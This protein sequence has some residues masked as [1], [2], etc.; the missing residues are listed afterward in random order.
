MYNLYVITLIDH[1][2]KQFPLCWNHIN[3]VNGFIVNIQL[4]VFQWLLFRGHH[5]SIL[6]L[7]TKSHIFFPSLVE[8]NTIYSLH[9]APW[10]LNTTIIVRYKQENGCRITNPDPLKV[11]Q[12]VE[13]AGVPKTDLQ[14]ADVMTLIPKITLWTGIKCNAKILVLTLPTHTTPPG[15]QSYLDKEAQL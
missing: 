7:I 1:A 13:S 8:N 3:K 15:P 6:S 5:Q 2:I 14:S 4:L 11:A 10:S 9:A 12:Q